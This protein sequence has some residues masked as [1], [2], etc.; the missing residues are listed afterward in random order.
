[1]AL[2]RIVTIRMEAEKFAVFQA[3]AEKRGTTVSQLLRQFI[4]LIGG[5]QQAISNRD[6]PLADLLAG[7]KPKKRDNRPLADI[8]KSSK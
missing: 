2:D 4:A 7:T 1:M 5:E 3:A 6:R 8:L